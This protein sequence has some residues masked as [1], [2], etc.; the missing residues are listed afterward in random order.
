M[1][2]K[3]TRFARGAKCG[4]FANKGETGSL[5]LAAAVCPA[6]A[7]I[8]RYPNPQPTFRKAAR[9]LIDSAVWITIRFY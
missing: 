9:L 4:F 8:A 7:A 1:K 3:I 6:I 5:A 2:T